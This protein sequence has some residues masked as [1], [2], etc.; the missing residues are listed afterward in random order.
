MCLYFY[1]EGYEYIEINDN[2]LK[3]LKLSINGYMVQ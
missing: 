2:E 3:S 1:L